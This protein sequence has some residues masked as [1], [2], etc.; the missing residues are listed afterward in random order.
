MKLFNSLILGLTALTLLIGCGS[1][2]E[3]R[4]NRAYNQAQRTQGA[5]QMEHEKV[6][7]MSFRR[8]IQENPDNVSTRL[9]NRFIEMALIR[10]QMVLTEG[11]MDFDAIPLLMEDIEAQLKDDVEPELRQDYAMFIMQMADSSIAKE[12]YNFALEYIDNALSVASNTAPIEQKRSNIIGEV[13]RENLDMAKMYFEQ[14]KKDED[15]R[16]LIRAEYYVQAALYFDST[17]SD[18][19][20]LLSDVRKENISFYSAYPSVITHYTDTLLFRSVNE[21]DI[22]LAVPAIQNRGNNTVAMVN[23]YNYSYNPLRMRAPHF[24]LVDTDGRE[25]KARAMK[26]EPDFVKQE[27]EEQYTLTFPRPRAPIK[28]LTYENGNHYS[29]KY[30]R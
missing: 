30:F 3:S 12:Q 28:K 9:R 8:A 27:R 7:F 17:L 21:Y 10:A 5:E 2:H 1:P 23:I 13:A 14:G 4:G 18:A 29:A 19:E 15:E 16:A 26:M 11:G 25:Y 24:A 20:K 6:A 22:L